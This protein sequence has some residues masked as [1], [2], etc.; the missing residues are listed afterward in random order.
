MTE[1]VTKYG[2]YLLK[3]T[4]NAKTIEEGAQVILEKLKNGEALEKFRQMIIHQGVSEKTA[5]DLCNQ[6]YDLVF[7][8][9]AKFNSFIRSPKS[10]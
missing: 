7:P 10:G 8:K 6:K 3:S 2:G 1:L 9:K 5:N 4:G